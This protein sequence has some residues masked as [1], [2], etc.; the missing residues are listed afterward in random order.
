MEIVTS[1]VVSHKGS[2]MYAILAHVI[3]TFV[4]YLELYELS[5]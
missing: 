1:A 3:P 5:K 4:I 2:F